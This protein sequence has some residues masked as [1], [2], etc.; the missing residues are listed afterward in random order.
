MSI[1]RP[2]FAEFA[3]VPGG[4]Y[5]REPT[6]IQVGARKTNI[7]YR[8]GETSEKFHTTPSDQPG[9]GPWSESSHLHFVVDDYF[10]SPSEKFHTTHESPEHESPE[11]ESPESHESKSKHESKSNSSFDIGSYFK[12]IYSNFKKIFDDEANSNSNIDSYRDRNNVKQYNTQEYK[13]HIQKEYSKKQPLIKFILEALHNV[14]KKEVSARKVHIVLDSFENEEV[15][16]EIYHNGTP[17]RDSRH[18]FHCYERKFLDETDYHANDISAFNNGLKGLSERCKI[19]ETYSY[20]YKNRMYFGY[21]V[22]SFMNLELNEWHNREIIHQREITRD[23]KVDGD[24]TQYNVLHR[25]KMNFGRYGV[26]KNDFNKDVLKY[27]F[28]HD[29]VNLDI[30]FNGA[31][32]PKYDINKKNFPYK[33]ET[34]LI[35]LKKRGEETY[36]LRPEKKIKGRLQTMK[37]REREIN[38]RKEKG[39]KGGPH[40]TTTLGLDL[41]DFTNKTKIERFD[42]LNNLDNYIKMMNLF[43]TGGRIELK[44]YWCDSLH[45]L[46]ND[47]MEYIDSFSCQRQTVLKLSNIPLFSL[48]ISNEICDTAMKKDMMKKDMITE[49]NIIHRDNEYSTDYRK[50]STD[51]RKFIKE[52]I[53]SDKSQELQVESP[54]NDIIAYIRHMHFKENVN[55]E[56]IFKRIRST[57]KMERVDNIAQNIAWN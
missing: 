9:L 39:I 21:K 11:H 6:V 41:F 22:N 13:H 42:T 46:S 56:S 48:A 29:K 5:R 1:N 32:I 25:Y 15:W 44:S 51:Y 49:V 10:S 50:Y 38:Q 26:D 2:G 57:P 55:G 8:L 12:Q 4:I 24:Y 33:F 40:Y 14:V 17:F 47:I 3:N 30:L 34:I 35:I 53:S 19:A 20:D 45:K 23:L 7:Q 16:L 27:Y 28:G 52:L 37:D 54:L 18:L 36:Y 31:Q 43:D